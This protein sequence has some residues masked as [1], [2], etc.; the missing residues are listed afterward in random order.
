MSKLI[1]LHLKA[2]NKPLLDLNILT[3][4]LKETSLKAASKSAEITEQVSIGFAEFL[5]KYPD[6][7]RNVHGEILHAKSKYDGA[8]TTKSLFQEFLK[9]L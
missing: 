9:T 8:E 6:K 3:N 7:N 4:T 1:N 2:I 5:V